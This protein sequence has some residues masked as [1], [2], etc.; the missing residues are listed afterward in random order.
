M[1][2][3]IRLLF[4]STPADSETMTIPPGSLIL[5]TGANGYVGSRLIPLLLQQGYRVR[6]LVRSAESLRFKPWASLV[7]IVEADVL[8]PESLPHAM[9]DVAAIYYFVHSM[10]GGGAFNEEDLRAARNTASVAEKVGVRRILYLGALG[11]PLSDLSQHLRS[12]QETGS[13]LATTS[14][15]VTE[16]RAAVVL[17]SGSLSFELIR[18]LTERLP[19][20]ICPFWVYTKIQPIAIGDVLHY[21]SAALVQPQS[22]GRVIE[23]GGRDVLTYGGLM[24]TYSAVRKLRRFLIP[25]PVLTPRLS[26]YWIW[27]ITPVPVRIARPLIEGLRNEV[28]VRDDLAQRLFPSIQPMD[29]VTAVK[30]ALRDGID[31][32]LAESLEPK[33][34]SA[35]T[36]TRVE[37]MFHER[38]WCRINASPEKV[39]AALGTLGGKNGWPAWNWAWQLRGLIDRLVGGVGMRQGTSVDLLPGQP[40]DFWRIDLAEPNKIL[41]LR[42]EMKL[43]GQAWLQFQ[44]VPDRDHCRLIQTALFEPKGLAGVLYWYALY[45]AHRWIF[46]QMLEAL[47]RKAAST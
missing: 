3:L 32:Q 9:K 15:P 14:V 41:R 24:Q 40:L 11:D 1:T 20:M 33:S 26:S 29:C 27:L 6:C 23:I 44:I 46:H 47:G 16:F 31:D 4:L 21:L 38:R 10:G 7:E 17:G 2:H 12:R 43:P 25:V 19:V 18:D 35:P 30:K 39:Y 8:R 28:I 45:P 37:G 36:M 22:A 42:A 34:D 13:A 5:V